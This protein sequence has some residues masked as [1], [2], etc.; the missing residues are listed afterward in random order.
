MHP[1]EQEP[2]RHSLQPPGTTFSGGF[3]LFIGTQSPPRHHCNMEVW[4]IVKNVLPPYQKSLQFINTYFIF[5]THG[6]L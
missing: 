1:D 3:F 6:S 4:I 2:R 5:A